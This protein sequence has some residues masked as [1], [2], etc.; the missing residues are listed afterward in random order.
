MCSFVIK[1]KGKDECALLMS[2]R[3]ID[4]S[5]SAVCIQNIKWKDK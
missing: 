5:D 1:S 2:P 4:R 3:M